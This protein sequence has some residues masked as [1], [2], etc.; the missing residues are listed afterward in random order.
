MQATADLVAA[1]AEF[2][3]G[4]QDGHHDLQR[5]HVGPLMM[6]LNGDAAPVIFV[7]YRAIGVNGHLHSIGKTGHHLVDAVIDDLLDQVMQAALIG[8]ADIH[9]GAHTDSL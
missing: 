6:A 1:A 4:V 9:T 7:G 5:G 8:G 3:A 2:A